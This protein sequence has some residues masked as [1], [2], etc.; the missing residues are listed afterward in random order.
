M[1]IGIVA[2]DATPASAATATITLVRSTG[3]A[4]FRTPFSASACPTVRGTEY[5]FAEWEWSVS[6]P[7]FTANEFGVTSIDR[8][9]R[10]WEGTVGTPALE[11]IPGRRIAVKFR[12]VAQLKADPN[13]RRVTQAYPI[14]YLFPKA[15]K[16]P[17]L[18]PSPVRV[19]RVATLADGGGCGSYASP[20]TV[21]VRVWVVEK[22]GTN[23]VTRSYPSV[24]RVVTQ[25]GRWAPVRFTV[26][27]NESPGATLNMA[28]TCFADDRTSVDQPQVSAP[29]AP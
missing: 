25:A 10:T 17:V 19:G 20:R 21:T 29:I 7:E 15:F 1:I 8:P 13:V 23:Y 22:V 2:L 12:C 4:G 6:T 11:G 3:P 26:P 18:T 24:S 16:R 5:A 28:A 9:D 27:A 14:A